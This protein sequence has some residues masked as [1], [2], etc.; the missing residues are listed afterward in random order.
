MLLW[1]LYVY[2]FCNEDDL[3]GPIAII[4]SAILASTAMARAYIQN[5]KHEQQKINR[6]LF[7][8]RKK[9]L[10]L[11]RKLFNRQIKSHNELNTYDSIV[12]D[13]KF[14]K[15]CKQTYSEATYIFDDSYFCYLKPI[16]ESIDNFIRFPNSLKHIDNDQDLSNKEFSKKND[17]NSKLL[18]SLRDNLGRIEEVLYIS[19]KD[20]TL[21]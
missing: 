6:E 13:A 12:K 5:A 2:I 19:N 8:R 3:I 14:M 7:D 9:I 11:L 20:K 17:L 21:F 10:F 15:K 1:L 18:N 16:Y 4:I